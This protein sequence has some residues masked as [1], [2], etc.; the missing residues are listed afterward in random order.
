MVVETRRGKRKDNPAKEKTRRASNNIEKTTEMT[1]T[2]ESTGQTRETSED[3]REITVEK[4]SED[5]REIPAGTEPTEV[6]LET[7]PTTVNKGTAGPSPPAP[8]A[9]P[10]IGTHSGDEE[11]D[12]D[13]EG[14]EENG[15]SEDEASED[16]GSEEE[17]GDGVEKDDDNEGSEDENGDG[18]EKDDDNEGSDEENGDGEE[19]LANEN[20]NENPPENENENPPE[21]EGFNGNVGLDIVKPT[22]MFFKPS[23]YSKKIK[24]GTRCMI[25]SAIKTLKNL[26]PKLSNAEW[27][28]FTEHP[29]FKHIFHMKSEN[30]HRVQGMWMLLLR[31]A[32]SERERERWFIVNGIAI[33]YGLREHGL[34]S[35]LFCHNYPLGYK[36]LGGTRFVDRHFKEGEPRRLEDVKKKLV[37]M[38]PHKDRLK[39]AVLFFLPSVVCAQTKAGHKANDVLEVF[40][41]AVDDL[42]YCKSFP[43]GRFSF[44][45]MLKE[46]SHTMEHFGGVPVDGASPNCPRM[47]KT[48]FKR[49]GSTGVSLAVI[50]KEL[51]NTTVID[52]IIPTRT[53]QEE[54]LLDE[55]LEDE[56]DV[57][58]SDIAMDSWMKCL[59]AGEKIFFKDMFDEDVA[60]RA[61][62][63]EPIEDAAGDGVERGEQSVQLGDVMKFLKRTMRLLRTVDKKEFV[64]EAQGKAAEVDEAESQGKGKS[65]KRKKSLGKGKKQKS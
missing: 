42:D 11:N 62:Q 17:N 33:R 27:S 59:D 29:Q 12:D 8:P 1:V 28:W 51:G 5:S 61:K 60:G 45:Y 34:I 24:L 48:S 47:C 65:Q 13:N 21:P 2:V 58:K 38:G 18:V 36:E 55:I 19:E 52:S 30:N 3:S 9:T 56:D 10:A 50:N 46:I 39:M 15:G 37:N 40:Q 32:G 26:K 31:T 49:N 57:D 64:K 4:T 25:A 43:W 23:E 41:R 14:S 63:P 53:P 44:D 16:E 6:A 7:A 20:D 54:R 35:G 22:S